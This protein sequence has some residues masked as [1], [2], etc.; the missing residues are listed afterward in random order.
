MVNAVIDLA[1]LSSAELQQDPF[2][3]ATYTG[4]FNRT[5]PADAFPKQGFTPHAQRRILDVIGKKGSDAWYQHNIETRPLIEL[6][7]A[8]VADGAD[9]DAFWLKAADDILAPAYRECISDVTGYDVRHL[10]MQ[11]HFWRYMQGAYFQPHVDKPHKMVTHLMYLTENWSPGMGGC[12]R[13]LSSERAEDIHTEIPPDCGRS[14]L[15]KR[16]D[17]AWHSVELIPR[18]SEQER[19]V[20]QVWFWAD[21]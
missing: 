11:A 18:G 2:P 14:V 7:E 3:W 16:T 1:A 9:L 13:I 12:F 21:V 5:P 20:L 8:R 15:L 19:H 6:G 17:N 10:R 4:T